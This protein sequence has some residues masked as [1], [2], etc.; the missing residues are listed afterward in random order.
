MKHSKSQRPLS[1]GEHSSIVEVKNRAVRSTRQA[2]SALEK[3]DWN[4]ALLHLS[5]ASAL[6]DSCRSAEQVFR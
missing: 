5:K 2:Q 6:A 1:G 4:D 3:G